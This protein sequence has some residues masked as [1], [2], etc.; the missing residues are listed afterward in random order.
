M[1]H[2]IFTGRIAEGYDAGSPEMSE[3]EVLDA[4]VAFLADAARGGAALE[5]GIGTG[6]VALPL[7]ERGTHVHG[8]DISV[9]M[10][11]Q[12]RAKPGSERID[13]T[14]GDFATTHVDQVF[15]LVYLV[16]N[17]ISN[18]TT[19]DEQVECF[20]NAAR[21]L[22]TGGRMV[23]EL[24]VPDL[25]RFPPGAVAQAFEVTD[26][27]LGFDLLDTATQQ[28][29]SRHFFVAGDRVARF[30]TPFRWAWP[31]ELD[32][33]ARIAGL[34]LRERWQDWDRSPFTSESRKHVSVWERRP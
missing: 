11:E 33:M 30:D 3:P 8:I 12:L 31:A 23:V 20:R 24:G 25:R 13:V 18:L 15:S 34:G 9:D 2:N 26:A 10:V 7:S 21:H 4:T 32:L 22:D 19:Q 29:V 17:V 16:Y 27:H 14:V 5:F 28:G 1:P 6:R